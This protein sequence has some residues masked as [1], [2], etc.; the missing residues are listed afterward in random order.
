MVERSRILPSLPERDIEISDCWSADFEVCIVPR[1]PWAVTMVDL[2]DLGVSLV[3]T[4]IS[5]SMAEV[6]PSDECDVTLGGGRMPHNNELL[7]VRATSPYSLIEQHL[8]AGIIDLLR[9]TSIVLRTEREPIAVGTP[10][11]PADVSATPAQICYERRDRRPVFGYALVSVSS[12]ISETHFIV[13]AEIRDDCSQP[14]EIR[15]TVHEELDMVTFGPCHS[16]W[17]TRVDLGRRVASF[18]G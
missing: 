16:L 8:P 15:S 18:F 5:P 12:P 10:E 6:D 1:G 11:Q 4:V 2:D 14:S 7:V 3:A 13:G 17:P 9:E